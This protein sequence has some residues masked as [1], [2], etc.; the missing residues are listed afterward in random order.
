MR[1]FIIETLAP[2]AGLMVH[3][4]RL[5]ITDLLSAD[6]VF[7]CNSNYGIWPVQ[8][9]LGEQTHSFDIGVITPDLQK[10]LREA[11]TLQLV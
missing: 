3:V 10:L 6:S 11:L 7:L 1:R 9:M 2:Q 4:K 8:K 5:T